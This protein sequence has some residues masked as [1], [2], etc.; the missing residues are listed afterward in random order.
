MF[1]TWRPRGAKPQVNGAQGQAGRPHFVSVQVETW[2][3]RS[4]VGSQEYPMPESRWKPGG[5]A[6]P[7]IHHPQSD[8]I[9]LVEA[10]LNLYIRI[11]MVKFTHTTLFW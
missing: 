10:P 9:K 5:V 4:H 11:L 2:L 3:L 1:M 6:G 7:A 8:S